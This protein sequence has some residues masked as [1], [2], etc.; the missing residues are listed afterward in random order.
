MPPSAGFIGA[1]VD[2]LTN[3]LVCAAS[4]PRAARRHAMSA[5]H[6]ALVE[7]ALAGGPQVLSEAQQLELIDDP[8]ALSALHFRVWSEEAAHAAWKQALGV[9]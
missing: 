5:A 3:A 9:L 2:P 4:C 8:Y 7:Q 6:E 1:V